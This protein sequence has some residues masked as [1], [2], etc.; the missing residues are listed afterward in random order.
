[1]VNLPILDR[2]SSE[3]DAARAG[4]TCPAVHEAFRLTILNRSRP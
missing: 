1:M 2:P 3:G 4:D